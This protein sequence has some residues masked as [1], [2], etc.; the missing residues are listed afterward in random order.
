MQLRPKAAMRAWAIMILSALSCWAAPPDAPSR[1]VRECVTCHPAQAKP[2]VNTP[3]AHAAETIAEC[4]VLRSH[5]ALAFK[6]GWFNYKIER[7]GDQSFYT[8]S[9]STGSLKFPVKYAF[10]L[11]EAG[12]T[13]I[14]ERDGEFYESF[15]SFY[16]ALDGLDITMG[17]QPLHPANLK[18]AAGRHIGVNEIQVCFGCHTTNA[19]Q[20]GKLDE[21]KLI[22]GVQC[23]HCHGPTANHLAGIKT[24]DAALAKM[25]SLKNMT[26]EQ[27]THFCGQCHRTWEFVA[28]HG[29]HGIAN[30]RFQPYRL[31]NSKC[32][33]VDDHRIS[34]TG[35]HNPHENI[36]RVA[37][38]YDSKC[39]ACHG[40]G[41]P[42][43]KMCKV[44]TK[45]CSTCHMPKIEMPGAHH[46]F[47][48]HEIRIALK[49]EPYPQ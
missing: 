14:L 33:D 15:V 42:E 18:E 24:G 29:P 40:G 44:A 1:S 35:C 25:P 5:S 27:S 36:D 10:G 16:K 48:D 2:Q 38:H 26:A 31:T 7:E 19:V 43:A 28:E 8:V 17:D 34:C 46:K 22:P 37:E 49:N 45:D 23:E 47:T 41:K 12:Q 4:G 13:Y 6:M 9:D 30:V 11:G 39:M 32:F 21:S 3:M 20:D